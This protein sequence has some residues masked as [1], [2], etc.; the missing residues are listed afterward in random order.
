MA[1]VCNGNDINV[2]ANDVMDDQGN[3]LSSATVTVGLLLDDANGDR[4]V[5]SG[6]PSIGEKLK[7]PAYRQHEL[8]LGCE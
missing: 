2:R 4:V 1:H 6:R 5:R 3:S 7:G 8:P